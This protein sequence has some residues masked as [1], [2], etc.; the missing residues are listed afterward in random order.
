MRS[1]PALAALALLL[2]AGVVHGLWT[3]RWARSKAID[4]WVGALEK[5]PMNF[6]DWEATPQELEKDV[7]EAGEIEGYLM[8]R[9]RNT[10]NDQM[11][12]VLIVCG[13]PGPISVHTPEACYGGSGYEATE[14]AKLVPA[15]PAVAPSYWATP[16]D[17]WTLDFF[18]E[19][20][21]AVE[22]LRI[23]YAWNSGQNWKGASRA[24]YEFAGSPALYKLYVVRALGDQASD[25]GPDDPSVGFLREF[26]PFLSEHLKPNG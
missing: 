2:T 22:K 14:K 18:K 1:I 15:N 16:D 7:L 6:G 10:R 3:E 4:S 24:R 19:T 17:F 9:Y 26:L 25:V 13:R 11:I 12:D 5:V 21:T 8:R 20:P 23:F